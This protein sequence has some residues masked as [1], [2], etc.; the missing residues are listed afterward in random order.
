MLLFTQNRI[1]LP[2]RSKT[3]ATLHR[4]G[5]VLVAVLIMIVVLSLLAYRFTDAMTSENRGAVRT[6]DMAKLRAAAVSGIHYAGA[7]LADP[8]TF[9]QILGG[10][11]PYANPSIFNNQPYF[12]DQLVYTDDK[13]PNKNVMFSVVSVVP[14]SQG[15]P[16]YQQYGVIDEGGKININALAALDPSGNTLYNVLL[17]LPNMLENPQIAANIVAYVLPANTPPPTAYAQNGGT[18]TGGQSG[19]QSSGATAPT[20]A[21][22]SYYQALALPYYAKNGPLNS[23]DELLLVEGV[24]PQFLYGNDQNMNGLPDDYSS[25][26]SSSQLFDRGWQDYLTVNGREFNVS[27]QGTLRI[28]VNAD[29]DGSGGNLSGVYTA[30]Q[31]STIDQSLVTYIMGAKLYGTQPGGVAVMTM[32]TSTSTVNVMSKDGKE[33]QMTVTKATATQAPTGTIS[34]LESAIN[35]KLQGT[36]PPKGQAIASLMS[37]ANTQIS[38]QVGTGNSAKTYVVQSPLTTATMN[39]Y[40]PNLLDQATTSSQAELIPRVNLSTA[41]QQVITAML[42]GMPNFTQSDVEG[43]I[44]AQNSLVAGDPANLSGAWLIT[45]GGLSA[46]KF[47]TLSK[48]ATGTSMLYRVQAVGYYAGSKS[49]SSNNTSSTSNWPMARVEALIDTNMGYT[50]IIYIR[51][52]TSLDSPRGFTFPLQNQQP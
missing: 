40:L 19:G 4:Q 45:T 26:G 1:R 37:L 41:S 51:D 3:A 2:Y 15:M 35:A 39:Q 28:D 10:S 20:G 24:T 46:S 32:T 16:C 12:A 52:L 21:P 17:Q 31:N 14:V 29:S 7:S 25:S 47:Q 13:N 50:R 43:V 22:S 9:S 23:L 33:T 42:L 38:F 48:Y 30:L 34:Q 44:A 11:A 36:T 27:S 18:S 8:N 6:A 49:T 5:Y